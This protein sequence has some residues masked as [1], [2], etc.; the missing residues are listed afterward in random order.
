MGSLNSGIAQIA[1]LRTDV[2][3]AVSRTITFSQAAG[4]PGIIGGSPKF[5]ASFASTVVRVTLSVTTAPSGGPLNVTYSRNGVVF[6]TLQ[7]ADGS[8]TSVTYAGGDL[9]AVALNDELTVNAVAIGTTVA[10]QGVTASV[11]LH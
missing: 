7:I 6:A 9:P 5:I 2:N 8:T 3:R 10:A 4:A 11:E 1:A